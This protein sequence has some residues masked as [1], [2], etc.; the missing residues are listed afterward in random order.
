M[1]ARRAQY[2]R[3]A[4]LGAA[5]VYFL[6]PMFAALWY[7]I[8]NDQNGFDL[9][10]FTRM[11]HMPNFTQSF[12]LSVY[13]SVFTVVFTLVLMVP[14]AL[15]LHLRMPRMRKA[16]DFACL[17]PL[18]VP[19]VV[20]VVGISTV[21]QWGP[22]SLAGTPFQSFMNWLQLSSFPGIGSVP[23][24]L[25]FAYMVMALPF[26]YRALDAGLK[27]SNITA[28]V[29]AARSLGAGWLTVLLRIAVPALRTSILNSAFL[30]FALAFGEFTV[31]SI[32]NF[33]TFT[34]WI[35]QYGQTDG[36]L[37]TALSIESLMIVWVILLVITAF[38]RQR[39][40]QSLLRTRAL[41]L[42]TSQHLKDGA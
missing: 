8:Y 17:L 42:F 18:V 16:V 28:L 36:Q 22:N 11:F 39:T 6:L 31:A 38:G 34:P 1:T 33:V 23:V 19:P 13:L 27:T 5:G 30:A 3:W 35:L 40:G 9:S 26:T 10:V 37:S 29:E 14:T 20:L 7:A 12:M 4:I 2:A 25:V 41:A 24:I 21:L 32:L 15:L